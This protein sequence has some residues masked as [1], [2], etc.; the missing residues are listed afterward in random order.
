M[1]MRRCGSGR[2]RE[3]RL[4]STLLLAGAV[5]FLGAPVAFALNADMLQFPFWAA[6]LFHGLR[7]FETRKAMHWVGLTLAFSLAFYAK[8]TVALLVVAWSSRAWL[9][10]AYRSVWRDARLYLSAAAARC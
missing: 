9:F 8:Y 5:Y 1:S 3:R 6:M 4:C 7:A 2:A 10:P